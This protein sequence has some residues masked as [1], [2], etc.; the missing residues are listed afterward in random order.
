MFGARALGAELDGLPVGPV[1]SRGVKSVVHRACPVDNGF[2]YPE[3]VDPL[4][5]RRVAEPGDAPD[6][7]VAGEL[8]DE[9]E[10][11]LARRAGDEDLRAGQHGCLLR[12]CQSFSSGATSVCQAD[13]WS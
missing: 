7:V 10:R 4:A 6:L 8:P 13:I 2:V 1:L 5:L 3:R 12:G 11:D 9:G